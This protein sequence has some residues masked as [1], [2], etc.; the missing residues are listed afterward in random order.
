MIVFI[1]LSYASD[2]ELKSKADFLKQFCSQLQIDIRKEGILHYPGEFVVETAHD[3]ALM[4]HQLNAIAALC[5]FQKN[6]YS[7]RETEID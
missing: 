2:S 4:S 7:L 6:A 3:I 1:E 5:F